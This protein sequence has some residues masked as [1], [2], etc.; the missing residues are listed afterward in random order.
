LCPAGWH[1]PTDG[2]WTS[3]I[4][5]IVPTETVSATAIGIQSP[6]A[7]GKLKSTSSLWNT[8]NT[9]ADNSSGFTAL[10]GGFRL[11][12]FFFSISSDA[13]FWSATV[14]PFNNFWTRLLFHNN[15][16]VR[17]VSYDKSVGA[18]VRCLRD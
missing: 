15:S 18:S 5:F 11:E 9:G 13:W 14:A 3:L 17:R 12:S 6:T 2:E 16:E 10:P 8:P 1:V 4:Q 7:S